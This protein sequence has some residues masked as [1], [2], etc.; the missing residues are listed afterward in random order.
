MVHGCDKL[1][2]S[3][4]YLFCLALPGSC[5]ARF[6]YF[7][8]DLCGRYVWKV[9]SDGGGQRVMETPPNDRNDKG[10]SGGEGERAKQLLSNQ[11]GN[12]II[13]DNWVTRRRCQWAG[14][15][16]MLQCGQFG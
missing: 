13:S 11:R 6:A 3:I 16:S 1:F 2:P 8:A 5:L 7:L 4:A 9:A 14:A 10:R 12:S 15:C